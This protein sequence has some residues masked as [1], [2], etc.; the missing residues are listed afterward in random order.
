MSAASCLHCGTSFEGVSAFCCNGCQSVHGILEARG[1]T[2]YYELRKNSPR[3]GIARPVTGTRRDF[4]FLRDVTGTTLRFWLEGVHCLSCLW[5]LEKLP[6]LVPGVEHSRLN[7]GSS[8]LEVKVLPGTSFEKVAGALEELG[9]P[10]HPVA[11]DPSSLQKKENRSLLIRLGVA[12]AAAGNIMLL[13]ISQY[14]GATGAWGRTFGWIG[15]LLSLPVLFYCATPF[16]TSSWRALRHGRIS[17]DLPI[18]AAV[19]AAALVSFWNLLAGREEV[20]F[21]SLST[22]VFLLLGSRYLLRRI[23]QSQLS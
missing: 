16:Y 1:L 17:I 10:P 6:D 3:V 8:V 7:L 11:H 15:A 9:Y 2:H 19:W 12:G 21:D 14:G 18:V 5:L 23:Q 13:A 22:L 4:R 20:Y